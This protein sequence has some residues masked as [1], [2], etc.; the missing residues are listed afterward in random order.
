MSNVRVAPAALFL[1]TVAVAE[2]CPKP[3]RMAEKMAANRDG[4]RNWNSAPLESITPE[5][6]TF[7]FNL[8]WQRVQIK[9]T[10]LPMVSA[11]P[12]L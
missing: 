3:A 11:A 4:N 10:I 6:L 2:D 5:W 7:F 1:T 9:P 12:G 8:V